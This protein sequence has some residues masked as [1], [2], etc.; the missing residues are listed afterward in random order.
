MS[1]RTIIKCNNSFLL[2]IIITYIITYLFFIDILTIA[3]IIITIITITIIIITMTKLQCNRLP[4][5]SV[6]KNNRRLN[7]RELPFLTCTPAHMGALY[8]CW[9][10]PEEKP[11][12]CKLYIV[13]QEDP[14]QP[15]HLSIA[16]EAE[17]SEESRVYEG[18]DMTTFI[19]PIP[20]Y[21]ETSF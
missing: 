5:H 1:W 10:S 11:C 21:F 3:I 14:T 9:W 12:W 19:Q 20:S 4:D 15:V 17:E 13:H 7:S 8:I 18:A 6:L 16:T 2:L